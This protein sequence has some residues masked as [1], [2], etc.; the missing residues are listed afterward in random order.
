MI[1]AKSN[2]FEILWILLPSKLEPISE[3]FEGPTPR[4]SQQHKIGSFDPYYNTLGQKLFLQ[5][6]V[7]SEFLGVGRGG[8][9]IFKIFK[10]F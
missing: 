1:C 9:Q 2:T 8:G 4:G 5:N 6:T 3:I 10:T 7:K